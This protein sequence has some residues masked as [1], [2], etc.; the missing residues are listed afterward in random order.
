MIFKNKYIKIKVKIQEWWRNTCLNIPYIL[1]IKKIN[2]QP[3][4][5]KYILKT[6][7][8]TFYSNYQMAGYKDG[9]FLTNQKWDITWSTVTVNIIF[10][11]ISGP[12]GHLITLWTYKMRFWLI[13]WKYKKIFTDFTPKI[14][15]NE[16][17]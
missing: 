2:I 6:V 9:N 13:I 7:S 3:N 11:F 17:L 5:Q 1:L 14:L 16:K 15:I 12:P 8:T 10:R 4:H